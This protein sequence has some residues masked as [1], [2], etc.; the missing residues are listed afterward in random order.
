[1]SFSYENKYEICI[2]SVERNIY[3]LFFLFFLYR[4]YFVTIS[5]PREVCAANLVLTAVLERQCSAHRAYTSNL[6]IKM[7]NP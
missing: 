3:F 7:A 1:M 5:L 6:K 2:V 4:A